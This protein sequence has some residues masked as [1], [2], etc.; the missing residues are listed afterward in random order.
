[1]QILLLPYKL[2]FSP[3]NFSLLIQ[4]L[5]FSYKLYVPLTNFIFFYTSLTFRVRFS[6]SFLLLCNLKSRL[7][8]SFLRKKERG[9]DRDWEH[10][11]RIFFGSMNNGP[12]R[13]KRTKFFFTIDGLRSDT[14]DELA[15]E[16]SV[17]VGFSARSRH[18]NW[19][20]RN[21]HCWHFFALPPIFV[22]SKN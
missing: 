15:C 6:F 8:P 1:M 16:P 18:E 9:L 11:Q 10:K 19:G 13:A 21:M 4:T 7:P 3:K 14:V 22:L 5:F 20:E 12:F 17:S 2:Y